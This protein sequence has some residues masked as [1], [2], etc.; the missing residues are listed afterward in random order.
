MKKIYKSE[1]EGMQDFWEKLEINPDYSCN[2]DGKIY[3]I[4]FE[5]KLEIKSYTEVENQIKR[6]IRAY[7]TIATDIPSKAVALDINQRKFNLYN[8]S[9][10]KEGTITL[11]KIKN[12][13]WV[14]P[15][16]FKDLINSTI[17]QYSKG[18]ISEE[19]IVSY[20]NEY[21]KKHKDANKEE[22]KTEF[23][24]PQELYIYPFEWDEQIAREE[25][26]RTQNNWLTFNMN[27]LGCSLLKKRLGAYFTPDQYVKIS[28]QY[29]K[30]C[31]EKITATGFDYL[32]IDT[33]AGTGN[34][35][36]FFE[37]EWLEHTILNTYDY[38]EWTTLKGLYEGRVKMIIPHSSQHRDQD[39]LLLDGDA[40]SE[41][42]NDYLLNWL[43]QNV[44]RKKIKIIMLENPP[45][46]EPQG[47]ASKGKA[48]FT[49]KDLYMYKKMGEHKFDTKNVNRD[50]ANLF[51]WKA[52]NIIKTDYYIVYSPIKYWKS[53]HIVDKKF[54]KGHCCNRK[55][56]NATEGCITLIYWENKDEQNLILELI[57]DFEKNTKIKKLFNNPKILLNDTK[58]TPFVYLFNLSNMPKTDNGKLVNDI[59]A[60]AKYCKVQKAY[61]LG[62]DNILQQ[63]P[64][65]VANCYK[66]KDYTEIEVIMKSADGGTK[67]Q[68]DVDF[69]KNC[70]VWSCLTDKSQCKSNENIINQ[71]CLYQNTHADKLLKTLTLDKEDTNI[72]TLWNKLLIKVKTKTEYNS[73]YKYGL[74]Q[75]EQDINIDI[76]SGRKDKTGK[77]VMIKK[78]NNSG[79]I[80]DLIKQLKKELDK[81]HNKFIEKKLFQYELLK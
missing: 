7:N 1:I 76:P 12:D 25:T 79:D 32:I 17:N 5:M 8:V 15:I 59:G 70:F 45:F 58:Q 11:Q 67:Y 34:L 57:N 30:E 81:Y 2:T 44:D 3:G 36:K 9:T 53:Q 69:L 68:T 75:I 20:N 21:C 78:Y 31:I 38:T 60:Y 65:W 50:L 14:S 39:G 28:T 40:L 4:L 24:N 29:L 56:F 22:V 33:C 18:W 47:N 66:C 74:K 19:S 62:N 16:D 27:M 41:Q 73:N 35:E 64:L 37:N 80:D 23:I 55:Y 6:Y 48:T 52:F 77:M 49:V 26:D 51:V 63:L 13:V 42:F 72:L 54:I 46:V 61:K 43:G 71:L 10:N